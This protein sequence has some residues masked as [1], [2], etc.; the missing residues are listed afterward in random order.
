MQNPFKL[1]EDDRVVLPL[2]QSEL[3]KLKKLE[4]LN[5]ATE[6]GAPM[7]PVLTIDEAVREKV[8]RPGFFGEKGILGWPFLFNRKA[9]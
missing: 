8:F 3:D 9:H 6:T 5:L 1:S 4:I 7:A 2:F